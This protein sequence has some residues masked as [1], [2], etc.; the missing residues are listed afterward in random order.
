MGYSAIFN[1][2]AMKVVAKLVN[3]ISVDPDAH[4]LQA[5]R[6]GA[7]GLREGRI[8]CI[9]PEGGRSYDGSLQQFKK[10]AA[11]LSRELSSPMSPVAINGAYKVWPR[12]SMRIRPHKVTVAFGD[13][14]LPA[15][16]DAADP[17]QEDTDKLR[18]S[19]AHMLAGDKK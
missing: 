17:Y 5:L 11:I 18:E 13:P 10:G 15:E 14:I 19:I 1:G 2:G 4:L 3:I 9:F 12:D 7:A 6:A 8:L 16:S